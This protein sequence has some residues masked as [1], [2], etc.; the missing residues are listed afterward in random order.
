M[1]KIFM[2]TTVRNLGYKYSDGGRAKAGYKGMVG[3]CGVRA[4]ALAV[5]VE[6]QEVYNELNKMGKLERLKKYQA[7]RSSA[8]EGVWRE[9]MTLIL[10]KLGWEW[11]PTMFVGKGCTV[12]LRQGELPEG[13]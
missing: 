5:D 6:Y 10:A 2:G 7:M 11:I 8:R 13:M 3:D 4:I 12:H 9:T 1:G